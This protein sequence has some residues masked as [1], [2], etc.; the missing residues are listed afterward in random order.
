MG[1]GPPLGKDSHIKS[2]TKVSSR[3]ASTSKNQNVVNIHDVGFP[4]IILWIAS[5]LAPM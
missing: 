1:G 5:T 4:R 3:D 2:I